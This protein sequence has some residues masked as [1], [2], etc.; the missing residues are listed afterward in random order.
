MFCNELNIYDDTDD[1]DDRFNRGDPRVGDFVEFIWPA[2]CSLNSSLT[3]IASC[4]A[5]FPS[6]TSEE[7]HIRF[8]KEGT[9][10]S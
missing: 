8:W 5:P 4:T 7:Q 6:K 9:F 1:G 2:A 10:Y 3:V